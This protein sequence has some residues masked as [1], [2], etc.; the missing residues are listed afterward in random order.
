MINKRDEKEKKHKNAFESS[1]NFIDK[2][3]SYRLLHGWL[4]LSGSNICGWRNK[5]IIWG[6]F[7]WQ[8]VDRP[9]SLC[10]CAQRPFKTK[11]ENLSNVELLRETEAAYELAVKSYYDCLWKSRRFRFFQTS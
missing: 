4:C 2:S 11:Q 1:I 8:T 3:K 7:R 5:I 10:V 6:L 9:L